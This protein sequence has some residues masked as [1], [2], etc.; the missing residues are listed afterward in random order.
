[1]F[2]PKIKAMRLVLMKST[3]LSTGHIPRCLSTKHFLRISVNWV[4]MGAA[5]NM[6][7]GGGQMV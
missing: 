5:D 2:G 7:P 6:G 3:T 4:C 1:M